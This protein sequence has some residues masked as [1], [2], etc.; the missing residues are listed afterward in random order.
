MNLGTKLAVS[1]ALS[2][3]VVTAQA[4]P[5]AETIFSE[6]FARANSNVLGNDWSEI[7]ESA[8]D[9]KLLLGA[10]RLRDNAEGVID[11]GI[12]RKFA[13]E[14]SGLSLSFDWKP[15]LNADAGDKFLVSW[16]TD[17]SSRARD[18]STLFSTGLGA[19]E[20]DWTTTLISGNELAALNGLDSFYLLFWTN[21]S[22]NEHGSEDNEGVWIDN[23]SLS[24]TPEQNAP[25]ASVPLPSTLWLLA[26]GL[27]GLVFPGKTK[28]L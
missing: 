1:S 11:A 4:A 24:R 15:L 12:A 20:S 28:K 13:G 21:L 5:A 27:V 17:Y 18:W 19:N 16:A 8:N 26:T 3:C 6:D 10:A 25:V 14:M 22:A 23:I 2:C 7:E 9:V